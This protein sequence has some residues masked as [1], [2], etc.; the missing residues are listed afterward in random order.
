MS[1]ELLSPGHH[2]TIPDGGGTHP[3]INNNDAVDARGVT[4][5]NG[6][7]QN[8]PANARSESVT[9]RL[10]SIWLRLHRRSI[11]LIN[12][13]S[14]LILHV[15]GSFGRLKSPPEPELAWLT[16]QRCESIQT[17][18]KRRRSSTKR[19]CEAGEP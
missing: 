14:I 12:L 15:F 8:N 4:T 10:R 5:S 1:L 18:S 19:T 2:E 3:S 11:A 6:N 17:D 13:F 7:N 9:K 16:S